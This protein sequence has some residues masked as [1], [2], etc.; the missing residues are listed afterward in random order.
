MLAEV[1][2]TELLPRITCPSLFVV[3]DAD[4]EQSPEDYARL[5]RVP[6][7]RFVVF[8]GMRHNITDAV[9]ERCAAELLAFLR[10][11]AARP[12]RVTR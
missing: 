4:P 11:V 9:P 3:P 8:E 1:D 12:T 10:D 5:R 2:L 7:H 6:D